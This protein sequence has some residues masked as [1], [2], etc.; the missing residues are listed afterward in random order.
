M[1]VELKKQELM[2]KR[3]ETDLAIIDKRGAKP[4][5]AEVMNIIGDVKNKNAIIID[6]MIDTAGTL[7]KAAEAIINQGANSVYAYA[8]HPVLS[9]PA[10][11]RLINS[12]IKEI[13]VSDTIPLSNSAKNNKKFRVL[14]S[15]SIVGETIKRV[16]SKGSISK[17][18]I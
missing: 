10:I 7:T 15:A 4:G 13:V 17:L 12:E 1:L 6:D 3:L 8:T 9:G 2:R 16:H 11:E 14:S 18:F 5:I